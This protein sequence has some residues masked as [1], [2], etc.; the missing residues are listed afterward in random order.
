MNQIAAY[1]KINDSE[2]IEMMGNAICRSG[3]FGC[4]SKEAGI[5]F[6]LQCVVENKPPLEMAKNYH[7]VKGKLTKRADAMLADFRRAGGKVTWDDLKNENVQSAIFDFE[8]NK[9]NGSFSMEDA[10]R[11]GLFRKG[12]A[13]DKTPAAMLRARCISETLRAIAPEIVQGVYVPEEIDVADAVPVTKSKT[14]PMKKAAPIVESIEV[15]DAPMEYRPNLASLLAEH[16]LEYKTNLYWSNKGDIDIDLDQTWRD[17]PDG[18]QQR[19]EM[20][21]DS[22]RKAIEK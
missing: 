6:A 22:F 14:K 10:Q 3:M 15:K 11:A 12:S 16:D 17:L 13:W 4:E 2:G 21:F 8:G 9:T 20:H 19:M 18:L 5:V 7:L 1:D